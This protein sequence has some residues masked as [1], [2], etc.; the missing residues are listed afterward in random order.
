LS[1]SLHLNL[2]RFYFFYYF[3]VGLF[4]P[5]W[6]LY[7]EYK[8]FNPVQIGILLS[9]FQLS[10]IVSPNIWGWI[11]DHTEKRIVWIKLTSFLG[12]LGFFGIF[13][14]DSFIE[15]FLI[16]MAMSIFTS[17]TLP[18]VE[19]LTLSHLATTDGHYSKIRAWGSFGFIVASLFFGYLFDIVGIS[20]LVYGLLIAQAVIFKLSFT[21]PEKNYI[22][23]N[24]PGA[25]IGKI[26]FKTEVISLLIGCACMVT[27]HGLLYNFYSIYLS[28]YNYSSS[29]IG[30]LWAIGVICEIVIFFKM[31]KI[32]RF[33]N[34]KKILIFS[35]LIGILRFLIIGQFPESILLIIF[36]Q[37]LHAITFGSFHI[38]SI[39]FIDYFFTGKNHA[40]GQAIYNSITYGVG[41][42]IGGLGG[43]FV[44]EHY[45][46]SF[47]FS[48]SA[49]FPLVGFIVI[50]IG[51]RNIN[52]S[53]I[54]LF[55]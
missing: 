27:S 45:G 38:A 11:A 43:G 53:K 25:S 7:L 52:L 21:I 19:S 49:I 50:G 54:S 6:G 55:K 37:T 31:P 39:E 26:L 46:A 2:S 8:L 17:S 29:V 5:Y 20:F 34:L 15:I 14:S 18:L 24:L 51:M 22:T 42:T 3:F 16:M 40:K 47:A 4:V 9:L 28:Q 10:R 23:N 13:W 48:L 35:L 12:F 33:F 32:I 30:M 1:H 44:I 41:G 36:A